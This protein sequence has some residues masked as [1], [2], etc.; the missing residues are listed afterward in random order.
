MMP[1]MM[2]VIM[3]Y[4]GKYFNFLKPCIDDIS[5]ED[6]AHALSNTSRFGGHCKEFYSVAQH[7]VLVSNLVNNLVAPDPNLQWQALHHDDAEAYLGDV[8]TPL[9]Q[10]LPDFKKIE[11]DVERVI[12]NKFHLNMVL[13]P[14]VKIADL[15]ALMLE[16]EVL[17]PADS[18][19]FKWTCFNGIPK[20]KHQDIVPLSPKAAEQLFLDRYTSIWSDV[21]RKPKNHLSINRYGYN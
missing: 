9:K 19:N 17:I 12:S 13:D 21:L 18:N 3:T 15:Q 1:I 16:R 4:T 14:V 10:L 2:P 8:P 6:I 5:I 7:S 20:P 11:S